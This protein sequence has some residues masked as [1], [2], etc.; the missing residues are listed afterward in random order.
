MV[1]GNT[2]AQR[3]QPP[4]DPGLDV[5]GAFAALGVQA[6][7]DGDGQADVDEP[8]RQVEHGDVAPV[9]GGDAQILVH[10]DHAL[11]DVVERGLQQVAVELNRLGRLVQH[12]H[13]VLGRA[14][15]AGQRR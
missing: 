13:H 3:L 1:V 4:L 2:A 10:H 15:D 5:V 14:S 9:P 7:D 11:V 8:G 12:P 6:I